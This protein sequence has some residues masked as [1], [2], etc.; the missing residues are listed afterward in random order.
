MKKAFVTSLAAIALVGWVTPAHANNLVQIQQLLSTR[1]CEGCNLSRAGLVYA[2]LSDAS[3]QRANLRQANLSQADL[4]GANLSYADLAGAV[5]YS[6]NLAGADLRGA[7]LRGAD[8]RGAFVQGANFDGALLDGASIMGAYGLP[9]TIAT[10]EIL[11][12]WGLLEAEEGNYELAIQY[13]TRSLQSHPDSAEIYLARSLALFNWGDPE[14]AYND[15]RRAEQLFMEEGNTVGQQNAALFAEGIV[16]V[17]T[18]IA[19]G[20]D[21]P[22]PD[23]LGLV[24]SIGTMLFQ[25]A[26]RGFLF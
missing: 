17:Q 21:P 25:F 12:Q 1:S 9:E 10:P 26:A 18:R 7:D 22:P 8:L 19:E 16:E 24:G 4:S 13:Y 3:L 23:F 5:L 2:N 11:F 20:P 15:A 14:T 6:A